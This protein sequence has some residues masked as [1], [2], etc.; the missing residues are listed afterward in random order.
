MW[1]DIPAC[2][3]FRGHTFEAEVSKLVTRLVH[4]YDQTERETDGAVSLEFDGSKTAKSISQGRR[5]N[6]LGLV[7]GFN[8]IIK[9]AT[10]RGSSIARTPN[11]FYF[12]IVLF[13]DTL[14]GS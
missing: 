12:I 11:M 6:I 1:N 8:T 2:Q 13:K 3:H 5:A 9:E 4:R 14:V 10:N 7:T